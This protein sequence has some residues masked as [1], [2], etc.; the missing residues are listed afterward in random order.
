MSVA[1]V[2]WGL[3]WT[4]A[5][6]VNQYLNHYNLT[7]L[8]FFIGFLSLMPFA[9]KKISNQKISLY[10]FLNILITSILF[11]LYNICFF[12]GTDFGDAGRGGVFVTTTNPLITF[13][14]A[15]LISK[16]ITLNQI[17]NILLGVLGGLLIMDVFTLGF[18]PLFSINN[19]YF[20]FCS[21]I[22]GVMTIIMKYGQENFNSILYITLCYFLT[23]IISFL[24]IDLNDFN[25]M[26][27]TNWKFLV[28]FFFVSIGAMSFGTSI[29]IYA[30]P[31]IGPIKA[32][33]FIFLVPFIAMSFAAI[34]L[35]EIITLNIILGGML[36][37]ASV[38]LI[39][40][41]NHV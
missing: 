22:W 26:I 41:N 18:Q 5:K 27:L 8:R 15:S 3:A 17:F 25:F 13:I 9:I 2:S 28:N 21:I 39:N 4:N 35:G 16:K 7:F 37:L 14:L 23:S 32:S 31:R 6:I 10:S 34:F 33:V 29:Y 40:K 20:I 19:K 11:F 1:M 12:K 38:Y 24:F 36:S 30:I